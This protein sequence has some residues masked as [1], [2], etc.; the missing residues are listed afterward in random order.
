MLRSRFL[1]QPL[2]HRMA[3]FLAPKADEHQDRRCVGR[4]EQLFE[5]RTTIGIGPV[6]VVDGDYERLANREQGQEIA[7]RGEGSLPQ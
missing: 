7:Q 6:K 5:Q 4:P 3:R 1:E 2:N